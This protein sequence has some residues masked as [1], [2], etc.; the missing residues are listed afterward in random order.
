[1]TRYFSACMARIPRIWIGILSA[2]GT[3]VGASCT[4]M[5]EPIM[6]GEMNGRDLTCEWE[7]SSLLEKYGY[8]SL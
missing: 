5:I 8:S 3:F 6:K 1:M 2:I 4:D 7:L